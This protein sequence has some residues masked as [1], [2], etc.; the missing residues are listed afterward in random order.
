MNYLEKLAAGFNPCAVESVM[1][2]TMIA[3]SWDGYLYDCDFN[4]ALGLPYSG[5]KVHIS[6]VQGPP[7]QRE[8]IAVGDHCYACTAGLGFT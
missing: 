4:L 1:C 5:Q 7:E 3:V 2:R 6:K 8:P